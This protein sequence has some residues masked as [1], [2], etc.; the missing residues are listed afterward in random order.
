MTVVMQAFNASSWEAEAGGFLWVWGQPA[1]QREFQD[2]LSYLEKPCLK[3]KIKNKI[4]KFWDKWADLDST[5]KETQTQKEHL[6]SSPLSVNP[7][8]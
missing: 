7:H 8:L 2:S 3:T 6:L 4:M 5:N 1:L